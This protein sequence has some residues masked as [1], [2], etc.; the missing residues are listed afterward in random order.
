MV[1]QLAELRGH[2]SWISSGAFS[3]DGRQVV[4]GSIDQTTRVWDAGSGRLL[5]TLR[6]HGD[7]VNSV[8]WSPDGRE[9]V[10]GGDDGTAHVYGCATCGPVDDLIRMARERILSPQG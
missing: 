6:V 4:T 5:S 7:A 8:D 2:S 3:P 9:I 10:S 1:R